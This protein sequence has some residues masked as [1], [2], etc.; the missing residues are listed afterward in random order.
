LMEL[1]SAQKTAPPLPS[2]PAPPVDVKK[3][4]V[5]D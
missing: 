4:G 1:K 2:P 3:K 5:W